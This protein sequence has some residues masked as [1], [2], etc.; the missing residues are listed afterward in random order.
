MSRERAGQAARGPA[1]RPLRRDAERNRERVLAAATATLLRAGTHVSMSRVAEAAGVG[2]G[3]LY[4]R[5]PSREHLLEALHRRSFQLVLD[6]VKRV[7]A[8]RLSG[9]EAL[10]AFLRGTVEHGDQLVM[11]WHGAPESRDPET[12][13]LEGEL[14]GRV[15]SLIERAVADGTVRSDLELLDLLT[16]G[17]MVAQPLTATTDWPA[18]AHRQI[19]IWLDGVRGPAA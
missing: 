11:T 1:E 10:E 2:V 4:R 7:E 17:A 3:T 8:Q 15:A 5:Y 14:H 19:V 13:R 12:L 9:V 6:L 18:R 16:F